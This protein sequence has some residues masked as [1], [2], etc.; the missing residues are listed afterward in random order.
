MC[1]G[2]D[3]EEQQQQE[4]VTL[5]SARSSGKKSIAELL[6]DYNMPLVS[7]EHRSDR[8]ARQNKLNSENAVELATLSSSAKNTPVPIRTF[9]SD[10]SQ[11]I[12][13][14]STF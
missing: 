4:S 12:P 11:P 5:D 13:F 9:S 7:D 6:D 14:Q 10:V 3:E 8:I 2:K 1:A